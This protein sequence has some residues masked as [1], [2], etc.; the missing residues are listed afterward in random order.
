MKTEECPK[1]DECLRVKMILDK[2]MLDFRY[3]QCIRRIC[4]ACSFQVSN[5]EGVK[6]D[7]E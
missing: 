1:L 7:S 5:H 4:S 6:D 3:V 2:D